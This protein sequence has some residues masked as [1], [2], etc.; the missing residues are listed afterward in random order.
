MMP[1]TILFPYPKDVSDAIFPETESEGETARSR[2]GTTLLE[3]KA[4]E[5]R[6]HR[7]RADSVN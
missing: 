2:V 7:G 4:T 6:A 5:E 3:I 1:S